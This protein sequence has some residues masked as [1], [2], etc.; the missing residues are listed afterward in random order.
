[1]PGRSGSTSFTPVTSQMA[2]SRATA[3]S[4]SQSGPGTATDSR[5]SSAYASLAPGSSQPAS[6]FAH[7]DDGY[8]GTKVSGKTTSCAPSR[9]AAAAVAASLSSVRSRSSTTGSTWQHATR[10]SPVTGPVSPL[11]GRPGELAD[12]LPDAGELRLKLR[13]ASQIAGRT[14]ELATQLPL[15][16]PQQQLVPARSSSCSCAARASSSASPRNE[17]GV[18]SACSSSAAEPTVRLPSKCSGDSSPSR[19]CRDG[20]AT[21]AA[22]ASRSSRS[23]AS[24]RRVARPS[25]RRRAPA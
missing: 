23:P 14:L 11:V 25:P 5:A 15:A 1:M 22:S 6:A 21:Q 2:C 13:Y 24:S 7:A 19:P 9:A 3:P 17:P 20:F 10:T 16:E 18:S 8:A 12:G 4:R